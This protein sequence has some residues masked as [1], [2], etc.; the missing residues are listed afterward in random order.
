MDREVVLFV[1]AAVFVGAAVPLGSL[2]A[3]MVAGDRDDSQPGRTLERRALRR[4][5][6]PLSPAFLALAAL[7]GWAL[8][9]PDDAERVP[10]SAFLV[11]VPVLFVWLRAAVR[12][13]RALKVR[14]VRSAATVGL[15]RPRVVVCDNFHEQLDGRAV[16]AALAHEEAHARHRDPLRI[17]LGQIAT[18]LQWP[19]PGARARF[20]H[21]L[22]A[23]ELARDE[24]ARV[25]VDGADLAA[26]VLAAARV[27]QPAPF[28]FAG[29][30]SAGA[31][32]RLR[33]ERLL[34]PMPADSRE[35]SVWLVGV[36][37]AIA[38]VVLALLVGAGFG[39]ALVR[40][41]LGWGR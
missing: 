33:V 17:W 20:E 31:A 19:L 41:V 40:Q 3:S 24:E 39:E 13:V 5:L 2:A 16:E 6:L 1:L 18:D 36:A 37:L 7:F 25:M 10:W 12:A 9:E 35:R 32:M 26:A 22:F 15:F 4:V 27:E 30:A 38:A 21:W 23:L 11:A 29:I 14:P 28:A 8:V 34:A